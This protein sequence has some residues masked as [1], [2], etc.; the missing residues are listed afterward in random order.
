MFFVAKVGSNKLAEG[1]GNSSVII[2]W[3][4]YPTFAGQDL[5]TDPVY[6]ATQRRK[7][8]V[9]FIIRVA[10]SDSTRIGVQAGRTSSHVGNWTVAVA[11]S[12]VFYREG[13]RDPL[14]S[15]KDSH[16]FGID[17]SNI[18][19]PDPFENPHPGFLL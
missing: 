8:A 6:D 9:N 7:L 1:L 17:V 16:S 3:S 13:F 4:E 14:I 15:S 19:F 2:R 5:T 18:P 12:D 11:I 10:S